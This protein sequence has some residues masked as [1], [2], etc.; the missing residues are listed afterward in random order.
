M[1]PIQLQMLCI[2]ELLCTSLH[3][4]DTLIGFRVTYQ[5]TCWMLTRTQLLSATVLVMSRFVAVHIRRIYILN[6]MDFVFAEL[7]QLF[8]LEW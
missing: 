2:R 7:F 4:T 5:S 3:L 8:S 1:L 6:F